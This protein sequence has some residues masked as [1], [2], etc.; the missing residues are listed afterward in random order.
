MVLSIFA[1]HIMLPARAD[2]LLKA[3]VRGLE[4]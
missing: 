2:G 4:P 1:V 3:S